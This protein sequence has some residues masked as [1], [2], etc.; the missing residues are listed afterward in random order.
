MSEASH[1][2]LTAA[3]KHLRTSEYWGLRNSLKHEGKNEATDRNIAVSQVA[4]PALEAAVEALE[5]ED[6]N[7]VI[8]Q[9]TLAVT[10]DGTVPKKS[11]TKGLRKNRK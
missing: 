1:A 2:A 4:L 3:V 10:T 8:D 5:A 6:Y 7:D 11:S 9:L